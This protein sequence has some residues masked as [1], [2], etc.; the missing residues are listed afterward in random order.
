MTTQSA[1]TVDTMPLHDAVTAATEIYTAPTR[2]KA[3]THYLAHRGINAAAIPAT[4]P[5]G[6]A[7]PG[8]T[9]LVDQMRTLGFSDQLLLDAGLARRSS[10]GNLIDTFRDRLMLPVHGTPQQVVGFIGRDLSGAIEAPKYLNSPASAIFDK[11]QLL[12]GLWAAGNLAVGKRQPV[13]VEGPLD[14]LAIAA[15]QS[16]AGDHDLWPVASSGTALTGAQARTIADRTP[17]AGHTVIVAMDGDSAGR[18]AALKAGERL[19]SNGCDVRIALLPNGEDPA[20]YLTD[21]HNDLSMF[22]IDAASPL[23]GAQVERV[24]ADQGDRMQWVEGRVGAAR[25]LANYLTTYPA[26]EAVRNAGWI[27]QSV[28]VDHSVFAA[29]LGTAFRDANA[30]PPVGDRT[31]DP[32]RDAARY[33]D[34]EHDRIPVRAQ[35]EPL[36]AYAAEPRTLGEVGIEL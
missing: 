15:R 12:Y 2:R 34:R 28:D 35:L 13:L 9:R 23:I 5:I 33:A 18:H 24:I 4:W 3:A 26:A 16:Q 25:I 29:L 22:R 36:F 11:S 32:L 1:S 31:G 14:V 30:L 6:Y 8:W 27:A 7:P 21:E 20:S 10:R 19:R 17:L